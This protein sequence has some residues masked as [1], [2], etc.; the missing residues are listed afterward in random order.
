MYT[1]E[2][3]EPR[4]YQGELS[5]PVSNEPAWSILDQQGDEIAVVFSEDEAE[6]LISH[7]NR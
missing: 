3:I 5:D 2:K 7:L 1:Y 6:A 4:K